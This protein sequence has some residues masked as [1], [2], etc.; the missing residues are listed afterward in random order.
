LSTVPLENGG[1][2]LQAGK[3]EVFLQT[4]ADEREPSLS[5]NGRWLAYASNE[6]GAYQIDVRS[7]PDK[8]E[9]RHENVRSH[10]Y[11]LWGQA[12]WGYRSGRQRL[13]DLHQNG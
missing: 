2:G 13:V 3:L 4:P 11:A 9:W 6:S 12:R 1:A 7:F 8:G 10:G 5:P